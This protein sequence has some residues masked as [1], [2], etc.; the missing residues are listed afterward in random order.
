MDGQKGIEKRIVTKRIGLLSD[1]MMNGM[2]FV[3]D[4]P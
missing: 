4:D 3:V 1:E 2:V